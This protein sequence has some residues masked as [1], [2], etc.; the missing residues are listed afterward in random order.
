MYYFHTRNYEIENTQRHAGTYTE[1]FI[2]K[3]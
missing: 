1:E 2:I 3:L